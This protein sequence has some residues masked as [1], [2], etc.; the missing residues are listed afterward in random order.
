MNQIRCHISKDW[1]VEHYIKNEQTAIECA[2]LLG[3]SK[4]TVLKR[5]REYEIPI[6]SNAQ[7][8]AKTLEKLRSSRLGKR[9]GYKTIELLKASHLGQKR[10]PEQIAKSAAKHRGMKRSQKTRENISKALAGHPK[11]SGQNSKQWRGG[12]SKKKYCPKFNVRTRRKTRERFNRTCLICG[13]PENGRRLAVHHI[14]YNKMQGCKGNGWLLVTL[15]A[16]CHGKTCHERWYWFALLINHWAINP[17]T[18]FDTDLHGSLS[19][20]RCTSTPL[21]SA[22]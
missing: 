5:L 13:V 21:D 3:Y 1:L 15:C 10:T 9:A 6:R 17:E 22:L 20:E 14:D 19:F 12:T 4:G 11:L 16:S 18:S 2:N 7:K 8:P